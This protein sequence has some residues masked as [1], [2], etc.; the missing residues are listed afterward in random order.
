[1]R[2]EPKRTG[3][4]G[5][6]ALFERKDDLMSAM[7]ALQARGVARLEAFAPVP[8]PELVAAATTG[9]SPVRRWTL[10]GGLAGG[11][12]GFALTIWTTA[13][14]PTLI[15]GGKPLISIPPF[16]II[17]FEL[18]ILLGAIATIGGFVYASVRA[19]AHGRLPYDPRFSEGHFGL[20]V[21]SRPDDA[22]RLV[23]MLKE[24]G[25]VECHV[26]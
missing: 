23:A 16:L 11:L 19:R 25:A 26:R 9:R 17:V 20:Y 15:T 7:R 18:T 21:T 14:W 13:Q 2:A 24:T 5:V 4:T 12:S 1:M 6:L 10:V 8:D 22:D 3:T